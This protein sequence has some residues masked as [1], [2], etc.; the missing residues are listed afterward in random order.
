MVRPGT[1]HEERD[2]HEVFN[3]DFFFVLV[4]IFVVAI[5]LTDRM[6]RKR[7]NPRSKR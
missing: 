3:S 4:V 5:S 6:S 2:E 1:C 7:V